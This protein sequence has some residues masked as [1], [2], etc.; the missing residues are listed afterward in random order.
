MQA[1]GR[2]EG[3]R[4]GESTAPE[5]RAWIPWGSRF[6][7]ESLVGEGERP[8][9]D[10][11]RRP[12]YPHKAFLPIHGT[13]A[14]SDRRGRRLNEHDARMA[15]PHPLAS[16][17]ERLRVPEPSE[18]LGAV[19]ALVEGIARFLVLMLAADAAAQGAS[20]KVLKDRLR[21]SGFGTVLAV[22]DEWVLDARPEIL[23][24][25]D[26]VELM[27][28]PFRAAF[29]PFVPV[30]NDLAHG[31]SAS[32]TEAARASLQRLQ[33][34]L[35]ILLDG[36]GLL[37]KYPFG[38]LEHLRTE[39]DGRL[40]A[41]WYAS[42]GPSTRAAFKALSGVEGLPIGRLLLMDLHS[43]RA[44]SL[45]PLMVQPA[46][47]FLWVD[48]LFPEGATRR[49]YVRPVAGDPLPSWVPE[50]LYDP[51]PQGGSE[52]AQETFLLDPTRWCRYIPLQL[53]KWSR[54]VIVNCVMPSFV[55][56]TLEPHESPPLAAEVLART[57]G[58]R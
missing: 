50:K 22:L 35:Q 18:Q 23:M 49:V 31:R 51:D 52:L 1:E 2:A 43:N 16:L 21:L 36:I 30:R 7:I 20:P 38:I 25:S 39:G 48:Q 46:H 41:T 26:V 57:T 13:V 54:Q 58:L 5:S 15:L 33:E 10:T 44:L 53:D 28:S 11:L 29:D 42:R 34:P 17:Y 32:Q 19:I 14:H 3:D 6:E 55:S 4:G 27:S 8:A 37:T 9:L 47:Y 45:G 24:I 56:R 12:R 40:A